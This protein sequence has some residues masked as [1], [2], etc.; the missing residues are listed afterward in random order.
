M[1]IQLLSYL[2]LLCCGTLF[3]QQKQFKVLHATTKKPVSNAHVYKDLVLIAVTAK[4]GTFILN[5][6]ALSGTYNV[7]AFGFETISFEVDKN[8]LIQLIYIAPAPEVLSEVIVQSALNPIIL[9]KEATAINIV[10]SDDFSRTDGTNVLES[11][12][13]VPGIYV[14]QGALNTNKI[15][16]RGIGARSQYSTN[17]IQAYFD[18][19]PLTSAEGE[20]TL[21]DFDQ[22]TIEEIEITKGPT[23]SRYGAGLGGAIH[24]YSKKNV[25]EGTQAELS[26]Q[27]GSFNT[28][29]HVAIASYS[30]AKSSINAAFTRLTSDGYREN[31]SYTRR[32]ALVSGNFEAGKTGKISYLANLT[33]LKAFIPSS[34]N[35]TDFMNNPEAAAFTWKKAQGYES[36]DRGLLGASYSNKIIENFTNST[37]VFVSFRDA[38]EPRPFDILKENTTSIGARTLFNLTTDILK[39]PSDASFGAGYYKEYYSTATYENLYEEVPNQGSLQG[40]GLSN[41]EQDRSYANFFGQIHLHFT[42]KWNFEVGF[43][44]NTTR[45]SLTDLFDGDEVNQ[46]GNYRFETVFSPRIGTSYQ[47]ATGKNVYVSVSQGF[48]TPT[49]AETLTPEGQINTD[50][51]PEMGINYEIGFKGNWL[52]NTLYTELSVYSIQIDN[53]LVAQRTAEDQY[54]GINAG[55]TNHNGIEFLSSYHFRTANGIS[56]KPYLST[57]FN[58]FEFEAFTTNDKDFS[59]NKLPG[60]PEYTMNLGVDVVSESCAAFWVTFRSVG[61]IP[62]DDANSLYSENYQLVNL[63]ASYPIT[64]L[65]NLKLTIYGGINNV[66]DEKYASSILTNAVGFGGQL[67]RYYYPGNPRNYYG[68]LQ[69][70]YIF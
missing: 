8:S 49:V 23:S 34:I 6:E 67:P 63:K 44:V 35:A 68:G 24:L 26:T 61:R 1:K 28:Q 36:Y 58:F 15:N 10:N 31:G 55:K 69:V 37:S 46:T 7:Q 14:N 62:L 50:L 39:V 48:S 5:Q 9:Q 18:G 20:L 40:V 64:L 52:R 17:R 3:A 27:L 43:N 45:Y 51:K 32:S 25:S 59:G 13:N 65:D 21:D 56:I 29:K 53:L 16:I 70:H 11:F 30:T 57:A 47:I 42:K 4:N 33:R 38:Y 41:N 12:N 22:E 2:L 54:I 19:I 60:V 66:F